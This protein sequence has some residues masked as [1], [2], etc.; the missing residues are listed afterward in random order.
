MTR[1]IASLAG[2]IR[3]QGER[4]S[5]TDWLAL[6]TAFFSSSATL[7]LAV[8]LGTGLGPWQQPLR[9]LASI[10]LLLLSAIGYV[11]TIAAGTRTG[12]TYISL[13]VTGLAA[14]LIPGGLLVTPFYLLAALFDYLPRR[15]TD[16]RE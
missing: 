10:A 12:R 3:R 1:R 2:W 4:T 13:M 5:T 8:M 14:V 15:S 11:A 6:A 16:A 9:S 7:F